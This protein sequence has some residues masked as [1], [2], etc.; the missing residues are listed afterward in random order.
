[1]II[2]H[3]GDVGAQAV[4][5]RLQ[6]RGESSSDVLAHARGGS[7][8]PW[9]GGL[10]ELRPTRVM[11]AVALGSVLR[12]NAAVAVERTRTLSRRRGFL[13]AE[14]L[15]RLER[16]SVVSVERMTVVVLPVDDLFGN[17]FGE[18]RAGRIT[19][20]FWWRVAM[21]VSAPATK[22]RD[23]DD[24]FQRW[25]HIR[26]MFPT[27]RMIGGATALHARDAARPR[28]IASVG[29]ERPCVA[30]GAQD[31]ATGHAGGG[32]EGGAG[33]S[34]ARLCRKRTSPPQRL[35]TRKPCFV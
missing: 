11:R 20:V 7:A 10:R 33:S 28:R 25:L 3:P 22:R 27:V 30:S 5:L 17:A 19:P 15:A 26:T 34:E 6:V 21:S 2:L 1:M 18:G 13:R 4:T 8:P 24:A 35:S 14:V 16:D 29:D 32:I 23:R 31:D 12:G 9:R